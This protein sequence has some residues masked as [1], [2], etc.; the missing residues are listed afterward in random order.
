MLIKTFTADSSASALKQV[1]T[2]MGIN[3]VVL[4]TRQVGEQGTPGSIEITACLDNPTI[5][6]STNV[7]S[8]S[9]AARR[10]VQ[11]RV[12]APSQRVRTFAPQV[13][14]GQIGNQRNRLNDTA[15]KSV[16]A[17][18][19]AYVSDTEIEQLRR[20]ML[21]SDISSPI[22]DTLLA[23]IVTR[24]AERIN[25]ASELLDRL[26][27]QLS[28][29][30]LPRLSFKDGDR[31]LFLGA[32]GSGKTS[33]MGKLAAHLVFK[34]KQQTTL[35]TL[36]DVKIGAC[37]EIQSYA[38]ILGVRAFEYRDARESLATEGVSVIDSPSLLTKQT[39]I[40]PL[41]ETALAI[42]PTHSLVVFSSLTRSSDISDFAKRIVPF[43]P[44]HLVM[45]MLDL[46]E[47]WGSVLTA[48]KETGLPLAFVTDS[49]AGVGSL[50]APDPA[51]FA[52]TILKMGA[53]H[54]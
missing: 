42:K 7:L 14:R 38:D 54:E 22:I 10:A 8:D 44:T 21:D 23:S 26:T 6:Q 43:R 51:L 48:A 33:A 17:V 13:L 41:L 49:P 45:T 31:V 53:C 5:E 37:E 3:A 15:S 27:E 39:R 24:T 36:D 40:Q 9:Q 28:L 52:R 18:P 19:T 25:P 46:T 30:M 11:A 12:T 47:R 34:E 32:A 2:E 16:A 35:T 50:N 29:S 20:T 4:K 1:R